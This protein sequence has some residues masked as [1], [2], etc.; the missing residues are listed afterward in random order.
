[1]STRAAPRNQIDQGHGPEAAFAAHI[2]CT[3][4]RARWRRAASS[5]LSSGRGPTILRGIRAGLSDF[6]AA[7]ANARTNLLRTD[8][9]LSMKFVCWVAPWR[10]SSLILLAPSLH[11][12]IVGA[13]LIVVFGFSVCRS[14]FV[15]AHR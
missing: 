13:V 5:V 15:S 14:F 3:L 7:A 12:N 1:M 6:G 2:S 8:R 9:D 11:M 4:G 10:W